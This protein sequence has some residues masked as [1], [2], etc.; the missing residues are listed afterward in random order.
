MTL[1]TWTLA[2]LA[3]IEVAATWWLLRG[4]RRLDG[5]EQRLAHLTEAL[6]LLTETTESGFRASAQEL[7][8]LA[9]QAGTPRPTR[10]AAAPRPRGRRSAA[11]I[12]GEGAEEP[13]AIETMSEGELRLRVRLNEGAKG[14]GTGDEDHR[15]LRN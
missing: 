9:D 10:A 13:P 14:P 1:A 6:R 8:R 2:F 4:L 5:V 12:K 11:A 7:M 3:V 15:A